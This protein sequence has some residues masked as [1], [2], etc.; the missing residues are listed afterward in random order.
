MS[1]HSYTVYLL[2]D[3]VGKFE[4]AIDDEKQTKAYPLKSDLGIS[5]TLFVGNQNK[6]TPD[7][8][9]FLNPYLQTPLAG[10][11]TAS[12]SAVL[13]LEY[14]AHIFAFTFGHGK[15]LLIDS[16][17]VRDF[18][19]KVTLNRVDPTK[20]RSIDA[21]TYEDLVRS[22]RTQTSRS[23]QVESFEL[24]IA[25]DLV[26][27][28]TGDPLSTTYFKRLTGADAL[29]FSTSIKFEDIG[30]LLDEFLVAYKDTA[31]KQHFGWIDNVKE[32][33]SAVAAILDQS[34]VETLK[35]SVLDD[36]HLAPADIIDWDEIVG[37]N[38]T[39]GGKGHYLELEIDVYIKALG[40]K[41]A[42]L[43]LEQLQR[44]KVKV[45]IDGTD[46]P[47]DMWSVYDCLIWETTI[48]AKG[49]VLFDGRWFEIS[50]DYAKRVKKFVSNISVNPITLPD[51][52]AGDDEYAYNTAVEKGDP[53]LFAL[54]DRQTVRP[55]GA[56]SPIEFC[57]LFSTGGHIV[58]VKKRSS[59]ATLSHLFSQAS[60]SCDIFLQDAL[61]R[62]DLA[63]KLTKMKKPSHAKLMP[64]AKP[65]SSK[66]HVVYAVLA[67]D[68]IN[69]PPALP[70]F[71]AVNLM[72]H[73]GRIQNLGFKVTLQHIK[74]V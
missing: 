53:I 9:T 67:K 31:Y 44:H 1:T 57:D 71:S 28:V 61:V 64:T 58:H 6:S 42:N 25:R 48:A 5:G 45:L 13:M 35:K 21:K 39:H 43:T 63:K 40:S 15:S 29:K 7:W 62:H 3:A 27:G 17:W 10:A 52:K 72:H 47:R 26:R 54:L 36:M 56:A 14:E 19:L 70:F 12:I 4:D 50:N 55:A 24:D 22:T 23:S 11:F 41:L 16:S 34:L 37:F 32:V 20:L 8:A 18:G 69:W 2:K 60:V 73:A 74:Q 30:D 65:V 38:F 33:D 59:S 46:D 51:A 66:Y 68:R 49:Y